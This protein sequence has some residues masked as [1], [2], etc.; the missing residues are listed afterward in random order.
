MLTPTILQH[1]EGQQ[2]CSQKT[3]GMLNNFFIQEYKINNSYRTF[4]ESTSQ[5]E[6]LMQFS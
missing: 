4:T 3:Y 5:T 1:S 6:F 2:K